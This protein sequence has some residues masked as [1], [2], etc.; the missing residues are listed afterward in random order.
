MTYRRWVVLIAMIGTLSLLYSRTSL[1][2]DLPSPSTAGAE[3]SPA[4]LE[5]S[6]GAPI[7]LHTAIG[8]GSLPALPP[9]RPTEDPN[10]DPDLD[11]L[12]NAQ[13]DSRGTNRHNSDTDGGGENDGS[14]VMYLQDPLDPG[15][16]EIEAP[17]FFQAA[18]LNEAVSLTYDVKAE[19]T[20]L[21]LWRLSPRGSW[22]LRRPDLPLNGAFQDPAANGVTYQ[23]RLIAWDTGGHRSAVL[24]SGSVTPLVRHLRYLPLALCGG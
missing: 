8:S 24:G 18:P 1:G 14:E 12:T 21:E 4:P 17:N 15:D 11:G 22:I 9:V 16:D 6:A 20:G 7:R 23:Y 13:E 5:G 19:Y 10:D 3:P 2:R